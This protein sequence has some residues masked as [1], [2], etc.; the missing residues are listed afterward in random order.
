M[1]PIDISFG[2]EE[3]I[4][5][6]EQR[7]QEKIDVNSEMFQQALLEAFTVI[8][9]FFREKNYTRMELFKDYDLRDNAEHKEYMEVKAWPAS[10]KKNRPR[11]WRVKM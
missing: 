1:S 11:T 8:S 9:F 6:K 10:H 4:R 7:E 2:S 5:Q 3:Y